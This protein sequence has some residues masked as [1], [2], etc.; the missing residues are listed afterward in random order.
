MKRKLLAALIL[1]TTLLTPAQAVAPQITSHQR[2]VQMATPETSRAYAQKLI[3]A[4]GWPA[5]QYACLNQLWTKESNWRHKAR[6]TIA[7]IQNGKRLHAFGIA[8]RLGETSKDP[9]IQIKQGLKYIVHR[10]DTPCQAWAKWQQRD[11][12]G[13]GWY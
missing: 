9:R 4:T 5:R 13:T 11:R 3:R 1:S 6:N 10:Y 2:Y 7:V 8:Q 12:R